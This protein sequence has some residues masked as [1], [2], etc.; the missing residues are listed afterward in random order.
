[1]NFQ[2]KEISIKWL[3]IEEL[4]E[5][6]LPFSFLLFK[7]LNKLDFSFRR[8]GVGVAYAATAATCAADSV[9]ERGAAERRQWRLP[10]FFE[11]DLES[12]T[13]G[14]SNPLA[15]DCAS[16]LIALFSVS[17][18][19]G[20]RITEEAFVCCSCANSDTGAL[21]AIREPP[22]ASAFAGASAL[23][24]FGGSARV[25]DA[26]GVGGMRLIV[27]PNGELAL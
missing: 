7:L 27:P 14:T 17:L 9:P 10:A 13:L 6:S 22:P 19:S 25:V 26:R 1:M 3:P 5:S 4:S 2:T 8:G 15:A 24:T 18:I 23:S 20:H 21:E 12:G 11:V 16:E